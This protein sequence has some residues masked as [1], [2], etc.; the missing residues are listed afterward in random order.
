MSQSYRLYEANCC[1]KRGPLGSGRAAS[2]GPSDGG[3]GGAVSWVLGDTVTNTLP[4]VRPRP[5]DLEINCLET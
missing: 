4:L 3:G 1:C 5:L 2:R